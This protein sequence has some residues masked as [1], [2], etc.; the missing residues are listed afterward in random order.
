MA[1]EAQMVNYWCNTAYFS[2]GVAVQQDYLFAL[3]P[4]GY[5]HL[6]PVETGRCALCKHTAHKKPP[7]YNK[8]QEYIKDMIYFPDVKV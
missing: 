6:T 4:H 8:Y 2:P 3:L 5:Q 7:K 1:R